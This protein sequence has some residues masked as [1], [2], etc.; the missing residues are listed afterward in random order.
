MRIGF[1]GD[2]F[3][4]YYDYPEYNTWVK[5]VSEHY[6]CKCV[7]TGQLGTSIYDL[8]FMQFPKK[9][10][11]EIIVFAW[12]RPERL[13]DRV[14]R[15]LKPQYIGKHIGPETEIYDAAT[16]YYKHLYDEEKMF[17]DWA[18]AMRHFDQTVL[19]NVNSKIVHTFSFSKTFNIDKNVYGYD[20]I[21]GKT[22]DR[23]L[24]D[25][26]EEADSFGKNAPNH[27]YG[28]DINIKVANDVIKLIDSQ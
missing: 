6:K 24:M 25:Y 23:A 14:V 28:P 17:F 3:C 26:A 27:L 12:S 2:S 4:A 18:A 10:Y 11:P 13:F 8:L 16:M 20:F 1:Y 15:G 19:N 7:N 5:L 9:D 21:H 22:L